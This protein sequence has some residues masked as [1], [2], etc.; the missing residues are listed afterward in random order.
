MF[1]AWRLSAETP[2]A[3]VDT[4]K[5][6]DG[7]KPSKHQDVTEH[8]RYYVTALAAFFFLRF[9]FQHRCSRRIKTETEQKRREFLLLNTSARAPLGAFEVVVIIK[10]TARKSTV[11]FINIDL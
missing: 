5:G 7:R 6:G 11:D 2:S 9:S 8:L 3:F 1:P 4:S 10:Q